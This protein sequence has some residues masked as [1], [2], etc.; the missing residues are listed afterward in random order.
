MNQQ[1]PTVT[2]PPFSITLGEQTFYATQAPL[3]NHT[4]HSWLEMSLQGQP[5]SFSVVVDGRQV[6]VLVQNPTF[7][8]QV[9]SEGMRIAMKT[10]N[11]H[12]WLSTVLQP[13]LSFPFPRDPLLPP[14]IM[15]NASVQPTK[16]DS[17]CG[18]P[19][20]STI[21]LPTPDSID[22]RITSE[23]MELSGDS[24][25]LPQGSGQCEGELS[26]S[27]SRHWDLQL[28][29]ITSSHHPPFIPISSD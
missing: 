12:L 20:L 22:T 7:L 19:N 8:A 3:P 9:V 4:P 27:S 16:C 26:P 24:S 13:P 2:L 1:I 28:S 18:T 17:D 25:A 6:I 29:G 21:L 11:N 15:G 23:S 5:L 14:S 10:Y